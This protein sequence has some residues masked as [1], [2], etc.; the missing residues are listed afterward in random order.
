MAL[1]GLKWLKTSLP[2]N[3]W[4]KVPMKWKI[5]SAYLKSLSKYRRMA[6]FFFKYLFRFREIYV[7]LLCKLDQ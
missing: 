2:G 4:F 6:F 7:C 5:I 1:S 3:I